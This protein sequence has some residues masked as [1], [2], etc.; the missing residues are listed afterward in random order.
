M[1]VLPDLPAKV[2]P[3]TVTSGVVGPYVSDQFLGALLG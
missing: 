2:I 3:H 1:R